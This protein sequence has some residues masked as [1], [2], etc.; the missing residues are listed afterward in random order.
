M[1]SRFSPKSACSRHT[2]P[3]M[4][5]S[6]PTRK[7]SSGAFTTAWPWGK[8]ASSSHILEDPESPTQADIAG[9][10]AA[11]QPCV[12]ILFSQGRSVRSLKSG[13]ILRDLGRAQCPS[14]PLRRSPSE[15]KFANSS[16]LPQL[17][18]PRAWSPASPTCLPQPH[19]AVAQSPRSRRAWGGHPQRP[20]QGTEQASRVT[21]RA[22]GRHP[23][24]HGRAWA[25]LGFQGPPSVNSP[26]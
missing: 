13:G 14:R 18:A 3:M 21:G 15:N 10:P 17:L 8:S 23:E 4:P 6:P 22:Q 9:L 24:S 26:S 20:V 16:H 5:A 12:S 19:G 7:W 11:A 2:N 1:R 25:R